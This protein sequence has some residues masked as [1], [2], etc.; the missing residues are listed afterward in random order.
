M[1]PP[2]ARVRRRRE[3]VRRG[4]I[5]FPIVVHCD[6]IPRIQKVPASIYRIIREMMVVT[7][8]LCRV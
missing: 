8:R 6:Y 3:I 1:I 7:A 2:D 5:D 4:L